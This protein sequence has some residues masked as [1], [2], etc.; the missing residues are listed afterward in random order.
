MIKSAA[1]G[2]ALI[3]TVPPLKTLGLLLP[4]MRPKLMVSNSAIFANIYCSLTYRANSN[5]SDPIRDLSLLQRTSNT[6]F[7]FFFFFFRGHETHFELF[8]VLCVF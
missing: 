7:F 5:Y 4:T 6:F 3:T 2:G 1:I 8:R